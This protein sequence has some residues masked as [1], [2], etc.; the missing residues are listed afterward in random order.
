MRARPAGPAQSSVFH[1]F[2]RRGP[3]KEAHRR[4]LNRPDGLQRLNSR[5]DPRLA[6]LA[7]HPLGDLSRDEVPTV[8]QAGTE[9]CSPSG[10]SGPWIDLLSP[11][12][13]VARGQLVLLAP[14]AMELE[15][16][17][18]SSMRGWFTTPCSTPRR[19][20][21][22][23]VKG[24]AQDGVVGRSEVTCS[25]VSGKA[26]GRGRLW[27]TLHLR[28]MAVQGVVGRRARDARTL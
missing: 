23:Q 19:H 10:W 3:T 11:S 15:S 8:G 18:L 12:L 28:C 21:T 17:S 13:T 6:I 4:A 14:G 2:A 26:P 9:M 25:A 7:P 5:N 24:A 1:N 22:A 20:T 16:P 27:A